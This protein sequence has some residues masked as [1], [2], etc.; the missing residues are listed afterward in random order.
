MANTIHDAMASAG[1]R[2]HKPLDL[3]ANGKIHRF[4]LDGDKSG[5]RNG[6]AV[7]HTGKVF[8]EELGYWVEVDSGSFGS[9][10]PCTHSSSLAPMAL[11]GF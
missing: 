8:V 5:S 1:L 11:S 3:E 7:L 2:P 10:K 9:W 4:R 6:W